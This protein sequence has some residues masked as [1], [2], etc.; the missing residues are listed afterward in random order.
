[1]NEDLEQQWIISETQRYLDLYGDVPPPWV[2]A[3]NSH[4]LSIQWRMGGG[5][6]FLMVSRDWRGKALPDE[7]DRITYFRKYPPPPRWLQWMA[8]S[9][10]KLEPWEEDDFDYAPYF[11]Q[12]DILG[13]EGIA[14]F[15]QDF[16]DEK[17]EAMEAGDI[18]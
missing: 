9:I 5:E 13:F 4:P 17:W 2:Y 11:V 16:D 7:K 12:L 3:P 8:I 1:M 10:W 14:E 6:G 15:G 18:D